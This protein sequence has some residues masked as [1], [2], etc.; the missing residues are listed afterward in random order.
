MNRKNVDNKITTLLLKLA[1]HGARVSFSEDFKNRNSLT[2]D[3]EHPKLTTHTHIGSTDHTV[4][5]LEKE[6]IEGLKSMI[7]EIES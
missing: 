3:I 2:I 5:R 6:L 1:H 4:E 7:T